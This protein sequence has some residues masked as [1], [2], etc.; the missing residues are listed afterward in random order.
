MSFATNVVGGYLLGSLVALGDK[1]STTDSS[2]CAKN[3][4]GVMPAVDADGGTK[5][6]LSL[7]W[8]DANS[9]GDTVVSNDAVGTMIPEESGYWSDVGIATGVVLTAKPVKPA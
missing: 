1:Y 7:N 3:R 5:F 4:T 6:E 9:E 2:S 8:V